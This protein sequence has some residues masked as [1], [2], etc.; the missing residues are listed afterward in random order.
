MRDFDCFYQSEIYNLFKDHECGGLFTSMGQNSL[1]YTKTYEFMSKGV[2]TSLMRLYYRPACAQAKHAQCIDIVGD[3]T[4]GWCGKCR[5]SSQ[6]SNYYNRQQKILQKN[7][8]YNKYN[9]RY[10]NKTTDIANNNK[11]YHSTTTKTANKIKILQ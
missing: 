7:N 8:Y 1:C 5:Q 10:Y 6:L 11:R 4:I 2:G 3:D 9:K